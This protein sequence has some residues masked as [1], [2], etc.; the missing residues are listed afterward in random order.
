MLSLF[1]CSFPLSPS[2]PTEGMVKQLWA[3][4][5]WFPSGGNFVKCLSH[6]P[7]HSL[8]FSCLFIQDTACRFAHWFLLSHALCCFSLFLSQWMSAKCF[9]CHHLSYFH[10]YSSRW[11]ILLSPLYR[12]E[13]GSQVATDS[14]PY[15]WLGAEPGYELWQTLPRLLVCPL[16]KSL[17]IQIEVDSKVSVWSTG[18]ESFPP[19]VVMAVRKQWQTPLNV[20]MADSCSECSSCLCHHTPMCKVLISILIFEILRLGD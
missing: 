10:S 7:W 19:M 18:V 5:C 2:F 12:P 11:V 1:T 3:E 16:G 8:H 6:I 17:A 15:S 13:T 20:S 14:W 4:H 9:T